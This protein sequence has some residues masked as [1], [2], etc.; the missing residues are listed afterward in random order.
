MRFSV[1]IA[2]RE[3]LIFLGLM[4]FLS[5][6]VALSDPVI[7]GT[8]A[9]FKPISDR[10]SAWLTGSLG[11][12]IAIIAFMIGVVNAI[13]GERGLFSMAFPFFLSIII[14]VGLTVIRGGFTAVI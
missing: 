13:R 6:F 5:I 9:T 3:Q 11:Y 12:V 8:D 10:I 7:A 14:V 2:T 4:L 1:K